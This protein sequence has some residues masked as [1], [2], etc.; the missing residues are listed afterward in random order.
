M[1][2]QASICPR[3]ASVC[4]RAAG[5]VLS[6]VLVL[7][8]GQ[9]TAEASSP[10]PNIKANTT[11]TGTFACDIDGANVDK[12][13]VTGDLGLV[14]A[15]LSIHELSPGTPGIHVIASYT[16]SRSGTLDVSSSRRAIA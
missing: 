15:A 11:I 3:Q 16:G 8:L 1:I 13:V 10:G 7:V 5:F 6:A 4:L 14:G 2:S 12:L 9:A